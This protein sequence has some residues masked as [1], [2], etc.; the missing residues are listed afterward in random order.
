MGSDTF[1]Q[2]G[3]PLQGIILACTVVGLMALLA[4]ALLP[5]RKASSP[6]PPQLEECTRIEIQ[7]H[8]PV[9]DIVCHLTGPAELLSTAESQ[10]LESLRPVV[11]ADRKDIMLLSYDLKKGDYM[12]VMTESLRM[13]PSAKVSCF[14]K[15]EYRGAFTLYPGLAITEGDHAFHYESGPR[16]LW[17]LVPRKDAPQLRPYALRVEC[18]NKLSELSLYFSNFRYDKSK[19][20]EPARWCDTI[21]QDDLT[22][23]FTAAREEAVRQLQCPAAMKGKCHYAMNPKCTFASSPDT[24]LLFEARAGWNQAG[25]PELFAFDHHDPKGGCVLLN[26]GVV[27]FIRTPEELQQLRWE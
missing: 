24:V 14:D 9:F 13:K 2:N 25:G 22:S 21:V 10:Y 26:N 19:Y 3:R 8:Q 6:A 4:L 5:A 18:A 11:L 16:S 1:N 7:W 12:G 17:D 27:K 15:H 23:G 20:P